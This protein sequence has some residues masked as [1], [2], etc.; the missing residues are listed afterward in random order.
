MP[1][2]KRRLSLLA[3][4]VDGYTPSCVE[5]SRDDVHDTIIVAQ[6]PFESATRFAARIVER[7]AR[8]R[9]EGATVAKASF[10][11]NGRSDMEAIAARLLV[12]RAILVENP[13]LCD[14][15]VTMTSS[16]PSS[17]VRHQLAAIRQTLQEHGP[18]SVPAEEE[19]E[20]ERTA[21]LQRVA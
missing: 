15:D 12:V 3:V 7:V 8:A 10:A 20:A 13:D 19:L 14:A 16:N 17:P 1:M 6:Q 9:A 11:C 21:L 2:P 18:R 5:R 4:E